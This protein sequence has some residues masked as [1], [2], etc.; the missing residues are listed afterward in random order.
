MAVA[1]QDQKCPGDF[2]MQIFILIRL[3]YVPKIFQKQDLTVAKA[4]V[5][6]V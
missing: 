2:A 3:S 6:V 4:R 5:V 1:V